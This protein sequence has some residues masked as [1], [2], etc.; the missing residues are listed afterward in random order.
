MLRRKPER[1][2][3]ANRPWKQAFFVLAATH[4]TR[5]ATK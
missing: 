1:S 4:R 3:Q 5:A 2:R